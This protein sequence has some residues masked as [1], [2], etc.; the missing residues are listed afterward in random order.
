MKTLMILVLVKTL[1]PAA[2]MWIAVHE[3]DGSAEQVCEEL[4]EAFKKDYLKSYCIAPEDLAG[5]K[6]IEGNV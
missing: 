6:T 3:D 2:G 5:Q 4:R 1:N